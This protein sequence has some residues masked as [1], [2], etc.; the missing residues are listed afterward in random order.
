[1]FTLHNERQKI[2]DALEQEPRLTTKQVTRLLHQ[3]PPLTQLSAQLINNTHKLLTRMV[4][5]GYLYKLTPPH[6]TLEMMWSTQ[7]Q[8]PLK[9]ITYEHEKACGDVYVACKTSGQ[10]ESWEGIIGRKNKG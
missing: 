1:M 8:K 5:E 9:L 3:K 6:P 7:T 2:L 10:L 4:T